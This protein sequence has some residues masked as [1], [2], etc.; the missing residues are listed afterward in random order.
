MMLADAAANTRDMAAT[1]DGEREV[2]CILKQGGVIAAG[3]CLEAQEKNQCFCPAAYGALKGTESLLGPN[4]HPSDN[5][6]IAHVSKQRIR[7]A[8]LKARAQGFAKKKQ[9]YSGPALTLMNAELERRA[10]ERAA[11]GRAPVPAA[12]KVPVRVPCEAAHPAPASFTPKVHA[13]PSTDSIQVRGCAGAAGQPCPRNAILRANSVGDRCHSCRRKQMSTHLRSCTKCGR[14]S[15]EL[16]ENGCC[17]RCVYAARLRDPAVEGE[18]T[19]KHPEGCKKKLR[20]D[21]TTGLC[22]DHRELEYTRRRN[23]ELSAAHKSPEIAN[24]IAPIS[25]QPDTKVSAVDSKVSE[26]PQE[27]ATVLEQAGIS[28]NPAHG[29]T[30][31]EDSLRT[32]LRNLGFARKLANWAAAGALRTH[33]E[34]PF[35]EV[36]KEALRLIR[37]PSAE[38]TEPTSPPPPRTMVTCPK[39]Q[40][41]RYE[42]RPSGMCGTCAASLV[43]KSPERTCTH[44]EGCTA[45]ITKWNKSGLCSRHSMRERMR[46]YYEQS[47]QLRE[48]VGG[49]TGEMPD[50]ATLP[51]DYLVLCVEEAMRRR[52]AFTKALFPSLTSH[53]PG[54][55]FRQLHEPAQETA[56]PGVGKATA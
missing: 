40:R 45:L 28:P 12:A 38:P 1:A 33:G 48:S 17:G 22:R 31:S 29:T 37:D 3:T 11:K 34:Q 47:K 43:R 39:C 42:L 14:P 55:D 52:E 20:A 4:A 32:A 46:R 53:A 41:K 24:A 15:S 16:S 18:R 7:L 51:H 23:A 49:A 8:M 13:E 10:K 19:C 27:V 21:N 6:A 9:E 2:R 56:G 5:E 36:M 44:P 30:V 25:A 54:E 50:P 26:K 35:P